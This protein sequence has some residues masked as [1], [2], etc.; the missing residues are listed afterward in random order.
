MAE[1]QNLKYGVQDRVAVIM[2]NH[3][4]VNA[5]NGATMSDLEGAFD[6]ATANPDVKVIIVTGAGQYAFV[7]GADLN[8]VKGLAADPSAAHSFIEKGQQV[9]GKIEASRKPVIA[10][11]NAAA[12][13]G[14]LELALA[15][16]MRIAADNARF[17]LPEITLAS[18]PAV[19]ALWVMTFLLIFVSLLMLAP[20]CAAPVPGA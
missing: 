5:F 14:G 3:P 20:P 12:A 19:A 2:L 1:Y 9:F 8:E 6:D 17:G 16:H 15:C 18:F 10:A 7:A 11:I 4:P 13:G